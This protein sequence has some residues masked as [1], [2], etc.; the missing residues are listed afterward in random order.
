MTLPPGARQA[1]RDVDMLTSYVDFMPTLL[2]AV[3]ARSRTI[4]SSTIP[5][6]M[7]QEAP[8]GSYVY[9]MFHFKSSRW[10]MEPLDIG[11]C[12]GTGS[13]QD[14]VPNGFLCHRELLKWH[15]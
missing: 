11:G 6:A 7:V 10:R 3:R 2:G 12:M 15:C 4:R 9:H 5:A 13:R 8:A 14:S 1:G